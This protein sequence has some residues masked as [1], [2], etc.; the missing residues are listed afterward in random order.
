MKYEVIIT[1]AAEADV[2]EAFAYIRSRSPLNAEKW[3]RALYDVVDGLAEIRGYGRAPES[4]WL[5][6]DL[7]QKVFKSHRIVYSIDHERRRVYVHYVR[8]GARRAVREPWAEQS[9]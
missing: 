6:F 2:A 9:D 1:P 4:D 5:D 7:H 3:L 8:H